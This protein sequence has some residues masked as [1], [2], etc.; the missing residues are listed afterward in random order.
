MTLPPHSEHRFP[1]PSSKEGRRKPVLGLRLLFSRV[2][3]LLHPRDRF[4][5]RS[6]AC[7]Q[8]PCRPLQKTSYRCRQCWSPSWRRPNSSRTTCCLFY[9]SNRYHTPW[10]LYPLSGSGPMASYSTHCSE[11]RFPAPSTELCQNWL[12]H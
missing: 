11:H 8:G 1:A 7:K 2:E 3:V 4:S 6:Q 5:S 10:G 9:H 12:R